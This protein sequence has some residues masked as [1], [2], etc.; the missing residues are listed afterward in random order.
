MVN[1]QV[2]RSRVG[3]PFLGIVDVCDDGV[4]IVFRE[5]P[6]NTS[7]LCPPVFSTAVERLQAT[8][9][10]RL[11]VDSNLLWRSLFRRNHSVNM[12]RSAVRCVQVPISVP[13]SCSDLFFDFSSLILS[14]PNPVFVH[15]CFTISFEI[16]TW[17]LPTVLVFHPTTIIPRQPSAISHPCQEEGNRVFGIHESL[18]RQ[19]WLCS[20]LVTRRV[21]EGLAF[22]VFDVQV[23]RSRVGLSMSRPATP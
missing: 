1:V 15:L 10:V 2:P 22:S 3:F 4:Q 6:S 13:T 20:R 23:P 8:R 12:I 11:Q 7:S 21:S 5:D 18:R 17:K 14:K 9:S 16:T 19:K